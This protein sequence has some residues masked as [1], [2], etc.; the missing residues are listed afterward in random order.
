ML[1][2][3]CQQQSL[4]HALIASMETRFD[5]YHLLWQQYWIRDSSC[6]GQIESRYVHTKQHLHSNW[7][8]FQVTPY[9]SA[10][11]PE[12]DFSAIS[13]RSNE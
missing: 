8:K 13:L 5:V 4:M 1:K 3:S 12:D 7:R 2:L 6:S 10:S 11:H 9:Q